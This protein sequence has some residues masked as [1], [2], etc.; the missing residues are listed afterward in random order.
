MIS[1]QRQQPILPN[2]IADSTN[3]ELAIAVA[4]IE[5]LRN[6]AMLTEFI[7]DAAAWLGRAEAT[8]SIARRLAQFIESGTETE[9]QRALF[10]LR[11]VNAGA[12]AAFAVEHI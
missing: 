3:N 11:V 5:A 9:I 7:T 8:E 1:Q 4:N 2:S 6:R 10:Q 12:A